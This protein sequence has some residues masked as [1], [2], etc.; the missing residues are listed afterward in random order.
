MRRVARVVSLVA[1]VAL[2]GAAC[3]KKSSSTTSGGG[4]PGTG[5]TVC[6]VSDSGGFNDKSFN[7][8][9]HKGVTA[10]E[11]KIGVKSVFL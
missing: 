1:I 7:Q 9:A 6:E 10:A 3:G 4:K 5:T 11:S 8:T 2:M